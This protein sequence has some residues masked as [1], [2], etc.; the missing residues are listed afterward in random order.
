[1]AF[2]YA[3]TSLDETQ[4]QQRR[5]LLDLYGQFAQF[6]ALV[7]L[8]AYQVLLVVQFLRSKINPSA[9]RHKKEH[10]SP[11]V[12]RFD[13]RSVEVDPSQISRRGRFQWFLDQEV[14]L[15]LP[16]DIRPSNWG[17]WRVLLIAAFWTIWLFILT[18]RD[19]GNDYL[20]LTKRFGIIASS[21]LPLHYLLALKSPF[22]P[23]TLLTH[24]THEQLNPYHRVLGRILLLFF[25][26]HASLYLNFFIQKSLLTKR[27]RD[28]D[29]ILGLLAITTFLIL[30]TTALSWVRRRSY[31][32]F[33]AIHVTASV[34]VLPTL[35]FH[36][37]H[38]RTYIIEA[39]VIYIIL[40]I[41]RNISQAS[42]SNTTL[43]KIPGTKNLLSLTIPLTPTLAKKHF[44]PGQ[45][46]Y[47]TLHHPPSSP[48][49]KLRLNP[50]TIANLPH[51]DGH[52]RLVLRALDGTTRTLSNIIPPAAST[53]TTPLAIEGPYGF[54]A[55]FPD[56]LAFDGVLFVAGGVGATFTVPI[57]RN[58]VD[59][60]VGR[61]NV[62]F[63]WS[64]ARVQDA[65]WAFEYLRDEQ[66]LGIELY[67]TGARTEVASLDG[68]NGRKGEDDKGHGIELQER[69]GLM[70]DVETSEDGDG[71]L[72]SSSEAASNLPPNVKIA[73]GRPNLSAIVDEVFSAQTGEASPAKVA[74]MVCGPADMGAA[75]R[76][77]VGVWIGRGRDVWWHN[78]EF[79][80]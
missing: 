50:F 25:S 65:A 36:V 55:N 32:L 78:E 74:V 77:E 51:K 44:S 2:F 29:V 17:T 19:T 39:G 18:V 61:G 45:H 53:A 38:L 54:A 62:R 11:V 42:V 56:F 35:Y 24:L 37:S 71:D 40:I 33:F 47:L 67:E 10:T 23:I 63:V 48:L 20:H 66:G 16:L 14:S 49:S 3:F 41:Q 13:E 43:T 8:L 58:L 52:F 68:S 70:N 7:P 5:H 72:G 80:W 15:R 57:F 46:I 30:G 59:Q 75:L 9:Q 76:R 64:V 12:S 1:M 26:L 69:T 4:L 34:S 21:Q 22:S 27:I 28:P 31:F 79:G 6:S 60:G 73:Q